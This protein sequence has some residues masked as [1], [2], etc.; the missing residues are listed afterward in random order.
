MK[1]LCRD[2]AKRPLVKMW[3][4]DQTW[5][6]EQRS[7]SEISR[8]LEQR[9]YFESLEISYRHLVQIA[10]QRD[11]AQ[12]L[13]H[14]T[15]HGDLTHDLLRTSSQRELAEAILVS[16]YLYFMF[17]AA[18]GV[19]CR[20]NF[21]PTKKQE[22]CLDTLWISEY[23]LLFSGWNPIFYGFWTSYPIFRSPRIPDALRRSCGSG[24]LSCEARERSG[25]F[26]S[27]QTPSINRW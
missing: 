8:E 10:L 12:Q 6:R 3:Y 17:L 7:C 22:P 16:Q 1:G 14:R 15:C 13:L 26:I 4:R 2:L 9:S 19:S 5:W 18:L 21:C 20:D 23:F 24:I 25:W 11:L 27:W